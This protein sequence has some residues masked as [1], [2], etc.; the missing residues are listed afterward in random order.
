MAPAR[1]PE[2]GRRGDTP[3]S[4][5]GSKDT[6]E[7]EERKGDQAQL[8][9]VLA[10]ERPSLGG[11]DGSDDELAQEGQSDQRPEDLDNDVE[12][13]LGA[14]EGLYQP[15]TECRDSESCEGAVEAFSD[16]VGG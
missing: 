6:Q 5:P 3:C 7:A 14:C 15:Q 11:D 4:T 12:Q 10:Q 1:R 13:R 16:P 8:P 2:W 9:P